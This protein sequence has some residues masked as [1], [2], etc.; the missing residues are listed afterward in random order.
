MPSGVGFS[1]PPERSNSEKPTDSSSLAIWLETAGW[2]MPMAW[3]AAV[4][5]RLSTTAR[6]ASKSLTSIYYNNPLLMLYSV[7]AALDAK[8][9]PTEPSVAERH[10]ICLCCVMAST[11][12]IVAEGISKRF[13]ENQVLTRVSLPV[14]ERDVVCVAGPSGSG[15]TTLLRCLA[16][17]ETPSEGRVVMEGTPISTPEQTKPVKAAGRAVRSEIGM[18]FQHFNLWPHMSVLEN[19][20]EAPLRVKKMP[21]AEAVAIAEKLLLKVDLVDKRDAYPARLSGGQQQRVAI[22]RALAMSPKVLR[23]D[24]AASALDPERRREVVLVMRELAAEGMTMLVVTHEMGLA[25]H[26][27][28]RTVFMDRGEIVEEAPGAAFFDAPKTERV[29]RFLQQFEE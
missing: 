17:L 20:I 10:R 28:T 27:G 19:L 11:P 13:G 3:A 1:R 12:I 26:V 5:E 2:V 15:K 21:R 18:V 7:L 14:M 6:K 29:R 25:R 8:Y 9:S 24:E 23:L 16:L 4:T 22:A